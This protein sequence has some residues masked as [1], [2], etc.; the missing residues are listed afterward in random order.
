MHGIAHRRHGRRAVRHPRYRLPVAQAGDQI[1]FLI[2]RKT[3]KTLGLGIPQEL[4][5]QADKV[6]E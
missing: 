6:I 2:N 1:E 5:L 4:L 3:A